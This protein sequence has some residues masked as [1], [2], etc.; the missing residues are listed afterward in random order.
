MPGRTPRPFAILAALL[1]M[2]TL[3]FI[4]QEQLSCSHLAHR[5]LRNGQQ[6]SPTA[7]I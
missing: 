3:I 4:F 5:L 6:P 1:S 2:L 7:T